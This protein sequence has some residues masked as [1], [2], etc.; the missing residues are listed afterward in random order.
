MPT[1]RVGV[2]L[3]HYLVFHRVLE[4]NGKQVLCKTRED[5]HRLLAVSPD[6]AQLVVLRAAPE[7]DL[8]AM[9]A[10][11]AAERERALQAE[12]T[13][14]SLRADG[15]R[16]SHRISYLEDQVSE[17]LSS[18]GGSG[19]GSTAGP[20]RSASANVSTVIVTSSSLTAS[21]P[22]PTPSPNDV[23]LYQKGSQV[24]NQHHQHNSIHHSNHQSHRRLVCQGI[25]FFVGSAPTHRHVC[26]ASF[27]ATLGHGATGCASRV[28]HRE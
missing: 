7:Q 23:Q 28:S 17:L 16:L 8:T 20:Q 9:S 14:D 3:T 24:S 27:T 1:C 18:G 2:N 10:Q 21:S 6:P 15:V 5:M 11:L 26:T 25:L 22:G 13:A 19:H 12:R 4:V